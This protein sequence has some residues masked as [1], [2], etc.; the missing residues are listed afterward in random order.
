MEWALSGPG[1]HLGIFDFMHTKA[2]PDFLDNIFTIYF[3]SILIDNNRSILEDIDTIIY[4]LLEIPDIIPK[5][6]G[7]L[8]PTAYKYQ[9]HN[10]LS[11]YFLDYMAP[12][13]EDEDNPF[14]FIHQK[15]LII[16]TQKLRIALITK[17]I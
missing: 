11:E 10:D 15:I 13:I 2:V 16:T 14:I 4:S 8:H 6:N 9:G 5:R 12:D 3:K 1:H 17:Q 7:V